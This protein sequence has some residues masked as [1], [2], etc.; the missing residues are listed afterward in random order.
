MEALLAAPDVLD[1]DPE[2]RIAG[3]DQGTF[4]PHTLRFEFSGI[5]A[6]TAILLLV[7]PSLIVAIKPWR[8]A[9]LS[10]PSLQVFQHILQR[11]S[12]TERAMPSYFLASRHGKNCCS[13]RRPG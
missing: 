13:C 8:H 4:V 5:A 3:G 2:I 9:V 6:L 1:L 12:Q 11:M 10:R 7:P